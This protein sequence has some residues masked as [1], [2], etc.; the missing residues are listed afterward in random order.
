MKGGDQHDVVDWRGEVTGG[1]G[2]VIEKKKGVKAYIPYNS[3]EKLQ[4]HFP[5]GIKGQK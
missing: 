4:Y 1:G 3:T 5:E 2:R